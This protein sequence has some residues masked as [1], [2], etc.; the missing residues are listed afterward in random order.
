[1]SFLT[2]LFFLALAALAV[3]VLIHLTARERKQV[4]TFPSLMFLRRIPYS[5]IRRRR[6][7]DWLLLALRIA[8]LALIVLAFARP[9]VR[10]PATALAGAS[11][12]RE[13]VI[14]LDRSYSMGYGD[15]W[16]RARAAARRAVAALDGS[17]R[18]TLVLFATGADL[19]VRPTS[20]RQAL[21]SA[22]DAAT[23]SAFATRYGPALKLAH[24][25]LLESSLA[26]RE[27]LLISDFQRN[28]WNRQDDLRLPA[29]T[30]VTTVNVGE[31]DPSD[32]GVAS[33]ML[34]RT[35][36]SNV[37][38]VT[39]TAGV[40]NRSA[41]EA[42]GVQVALEIDGR[43]I[44]GR[45]VTVPPH[46]SA[47]VAFDPVILAAPYTRGS[48]VA[49]RDRLALNDAFHF[50]LSPVQPLPVLLVEPVF[51]GRDSSLYL[52]RALGVGTSPPVRVQVK[53]AGQVGGADLDA[54]LASR[55]GAGVVILNDV[56]V[57]GGQLD[58]VRQFVERG[59]GLLVVLGER[60]SWASDAGDLLPAMPGRIVDRPAG[61]GGMLGD[62]DYAHPIFEVFKGPRSGDFSS[63]RFF[64]HRSIAEQ[65]PR[66]APGGGPPANPV[67]V[68]ARF[69]DGTPALLE[70]DIGRGRVIMWSS[71][72]DNFWNDLVLKPVFVP[73]LH[74]TVR[75]LSAYRESAEWV[76][77]GTVVDTGAGMP[78][79]GS[80][81]ALSPTT[82]LTP[83]G[84]HV[85]LAAG[86][87]PAFEFSEPG[88]FEFRASNAREDRAPTIAA[89]V[90][91]AESDLS[92]LDL[93]EFGAA[94][95]GQ[96][97]AGQGRSREAPQRT[98]ADQER[99]QALWRYLL[100]AGLVLLGL[101][102]VLSNRLTRSR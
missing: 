67:R 57:A 65:E 31:P 6:I 72:L 90:D 97:D 79:L 22:I 76:E 10:R 47:S 32:L 34:Q 27:L 40:V 14:L 24:R 9:F 78:G 66:Q 59:G 81:G 74:Q 54:L 82:V 83:S 69:D 50:V 60:A 33:V 16:D 45:P 55:L 98:A 7:R 62:L 1:M 35:V 11:G 51:A 80:G 70:R 88:F 20:D 96:A 91:P 36:R 42:A 100:M 25:V 71:T 85:S 87:G 92:P 64:R 52:T 19:A 3:P 5:S 37:E 17:D 43:Q 23:V 30:R 21:V 44:Q 75:Y 8:A 2:P 63:A 13:V 18:A 93:A 61:R 49:P 58:R 48:V 77:V 26:S 101:E 95:S 56:A 102:S 99:E 29:R 12:P 4:V 84:Q 41:G 15:H 38:R 28:G 68:L 46:G 89:N 86:D 94:L 39:A 53:P 73:F